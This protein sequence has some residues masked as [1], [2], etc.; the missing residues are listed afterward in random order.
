MTPDIQSTAAPAVL[1]CKACGRGTN[2]TNDGLCI[3]CVCGC[4][5]ARVLRAALA[6]LK[7]TVEQYPVGVDVAMALAQAETAL[8]K[9][10]TDG[11]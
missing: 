4:E 11:H 3:Q 8:G 9:E 10:G 5:E 1:T 6:Q 2:T 7:A